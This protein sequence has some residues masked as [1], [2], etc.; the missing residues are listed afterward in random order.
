[1]FGLTTVTPEEPPAQ[2]RNLQKRSNPLFA[3]QSNRLGAA[4]YIKFA[5]DG[6]DM[7]LGR[8]LCNRRLRSDELVGLAYRQQAPDLR[9]VTLYLGIPLID[10]YALDVVRIRGERGLPQQFGGKHAFRTHPPTQ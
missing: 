6:L 7:G 5:E 8:D 2:G 3:G 10:L 1:M 4:Q 9:F